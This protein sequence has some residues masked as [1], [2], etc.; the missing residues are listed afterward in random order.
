MKIDSIPSVE[1]TISILQV[2]LNDTPIYF[3]YDKAMYAMARVHNK[4]GVLKPMLE[5]ALSEYIPGIDARSSLISFLSSSP[6]GKNWTWKTEQGDV[7]TNKEALAGALNSPIFSEEF[8]GKIQLYSDYQKLTKYRSTLQN[9]FMFGTISN[10]MSRDRSRMLE[11]RPTITPQNTG[12]LGY[13]DPAIQNINRDLQELQTAPY[14]YNKIHCDSRQLEPRIIISEVLKDPIIKRLVELYD[15]AYYAYYHFCMY[16]ETL[17]QP[18]SELKAKEITDEMVRGRQKIKTYGNG[19]MYGSTSNPEGDP[20][21]DAMIKYIGQHPGRLQYI[22]KLKEFINRRKQIPT[23]FGTNINI[24]QS[25]KLRN[26]RPSYYEKELEKLAINNSIQGTAAD[27]MRASVINASNMILSAGG[28]ARIA[29]Y[30]HDAAVLIVPDD[31]MEL[32]RPLYEDIVTYD[33]DGWV[34]IP[35]ETE[36]NKEWKDIW[37]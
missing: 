34:P 22:E 31:E 28:K 11:V 21:K 16:R 3:D 6:E 19:V 36:I 15:D 23:Y 27:M 20:V 12:R 33:V 7:S 1:Q 35:Q 2:H 30:I 9:L 14:G 32:L 13:S 37:S 25:I 29:E 10:K 24:Y 8:K 18:L 17:S 26:E 5:E 4:C